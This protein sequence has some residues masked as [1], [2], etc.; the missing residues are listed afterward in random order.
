MPT[1][2]SDSK[3]SSLVVEKTLRG[4]G[5][6][7]LNSLTIPGGKPGY[8]LAKTAT[9]SQWS[10]FSG[11]G[12]LFTKCSL[13]ESLPIDSITAIFWDDVTDDLAIYNNENGRIT[14]KTPG[15]YRVSMAGCVIRERDLSSTWGMITI[16]GTKENP[17]QIFVK[18]APPGAESDS[19]LSAGFMS[20]MTYLQAGFSFASVIIADS[21][22]LAGL[23]E[24][25][26]VISP[27]SLLIEFIRP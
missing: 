13:I 12:G 15:W 6:T 25:D 8:V 3:L 14:I 18:V 23:K 21:G 11:S 1:I 19:Q 27:T 26:V 5:R 4:K 20:Q 7:V 16:T 24:P 17:G 10:P 22:M 2:I 9:G